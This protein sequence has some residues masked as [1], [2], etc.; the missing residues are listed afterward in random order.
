MV[1]AALRVNCR[2]STLAAMNEDTPA[3][4]VLKPSDLPAHLLDAVI[5]EFVSREGTDY[6]HADVDH[7]E[8]VSAVRAQLKRGEAAVVFD[9]DTE[10]TSIVP[11]HKGVPTAR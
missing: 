1:D 6:G 5:S 3:P 10:S 4:V 8:K 2:A 7:E 11:A 9:P